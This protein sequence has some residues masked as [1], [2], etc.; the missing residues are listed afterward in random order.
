[1]SHLAVGIF[2][3]R[4]LAFIAIERIVLVW[5]L[6]YS[7]RVKT[8]PIHQTGHTGRNL[9]TVH[10]SD[11]CSRGSSHGYNRVGTGCKYCWARGIRKP[12]TLLLYKPATCSKFPSKPVARSE[13][14][15]DSRSCSISTTKFN[16]IHDRLKQT[17]PLQH[18]KHMNH[19]RI[20]SCSVRNK[21][22][23]GWYTAG[24]QPNR[25][26]GVLEV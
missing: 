2:C 3:V 18:R 22:S 13:T 7:A 19:G 15:H 21:N 16:Q 20:P 17:K 24:Q 1:M 14:W 9:L 8:T 12:S 6:P 5:F 4:L 25:K 26:V 10:V 23:T 11:P